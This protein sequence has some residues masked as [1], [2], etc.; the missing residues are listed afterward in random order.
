M[1]TASARGGLQ[2]LPMVGFSK[3]IGLSFHGI[4]PVGCSHAVI[5]FDFDFP[6]NY[7]LHLALTV[8]F[9][10]VIYSSMNIYFVKQVNY[11]RR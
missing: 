4:V 5:L 2:P 9:S 1:F 7:L 8:L 11:F 6:V 10:T 3:K